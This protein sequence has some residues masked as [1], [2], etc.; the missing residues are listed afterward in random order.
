M[1]QADMQSYQPPLIG[2]GVETAPVV[3]DGRQ[4]EA[5]EAAPAGA[6]AEELE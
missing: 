3:R 1:L 2:L 4:D 5:L 6:Q